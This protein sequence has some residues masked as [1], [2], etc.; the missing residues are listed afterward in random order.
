MAAAVDPHHA[1]GIAPRRDL[2]LP[3]LE[4]E[5]PA[6]HQQH[7]GPLPV[8]AIAQPNAV[9][10]QVVIRRTAV[11]RAA[12][13]V[14][15]HATRYSYSEKFFAFR[16]RPAARRPSSAERAA[17]ARQICALSDS[18]GTVAR[19]AEICRLTC[20]SIARRSRTSL[21]RGDAARVARGVERG[22]HAPL[23]IE[24]R[25]G[26]RDDAVGEFVLDR[27]VAAAAALLDERAQLRRVG[28]GTLGERLEPGGL[29]VALQ[30]L[31]A[32]ARRAA[33]GRWRSRAPG[34]RLPTWA[35]SRSSVRTEARATYTISTPSSTHSA[36]ESA[37]L[38]AS[39]SR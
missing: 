4:I 33:R 18:Q 28:D 12:R 14:R 6:V 30:A 31:G 35:S 8:V 1:E 36:A 32:H 39:S 34:K 21:R 13:G 37:V 7:G 3:H 23:M 38:R 29:E 19:S 5:R 2:R 9:D 27:R 17:A 24:H 20:C 11:R 26:E 22:D 16:L 10:D 25:Y 15:A